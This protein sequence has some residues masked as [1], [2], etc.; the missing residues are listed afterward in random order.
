V[1]PGRPLGSRPWEP[2]SPSASA[3]RTLVLGDKDLKT[4]L[5][6]NSMSLVMLALFLGFWIGQALT[7][8]RHHNQEQLE[9]GQQEISLSQFVRNGEFIETTFE[10]WESEFFQMA[11]FVWLSAFLV[12]RGSAEAKG[13]DEDSE[14]IEK[15]KKRDSPGPVHRG[16]LALALYQRSLS[17]T[18]FALFL[19]SF[20]MHAVGGKMKF[21]EEQLQH[22]QQT[23]SMLGYV[24]SS[25]FWYESFQN[26]QSEFLS[27]FALVVLSIWLRQKDSPESKKVTAPHRSNEA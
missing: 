10:N 13:P 14:D 15:E 21:N 3:G 2:P 25:T 24:G 12:Q 5:K 20:A 16:G 1:T 8:L 11:A 18:L 6:N 17:L 7:G 4:F 26:W 9:H 23:V 22:G 27:V 19:F